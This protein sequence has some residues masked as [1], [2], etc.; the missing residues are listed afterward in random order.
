VFWQEKWSGFQLS[1]ALIQPTSPSLYTATDSS[2]EAV[3]KTNC[4]MWV[5]SFLIEQ[6][7]QEKIKVGGCFGCPEP[8]PLMP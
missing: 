8:S 7:L 3:L 1:Q 2:C 4:L 5:D 6:F